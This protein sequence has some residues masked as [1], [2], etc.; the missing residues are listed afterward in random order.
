MFRIKDQFAKLQNPYTFGVPV[1]GKDNFFGRE[2]E[3]Q[4]IFDTLENVPR[5]QKQDLVVMGPR[6]IGKSSLL[7]RLVD[8]LTPRKDFVSVYIDVQ[9]IKPRTTR[10][11]FFEVMQ[12]IEDGYSKKGIWSRHLPSFVTLKPDNIPVDLEFY[13][14]K[15]DMIRLNEVIVSQNLPRLV[16]MFDEVELLIE[17]GGADI[18][19]WFRGLIQSMLYII[20][21]VSGA[22]QLYSL[23]QDYGSPFYNIFK[24]IELHPLTPRAARK[25]IEEPANQIGMQIPSTEVDKIL[26][27]AGNSPY[28][29][30]GMAHYLVETLNRQKRY[31]V[32][33]EDVAEVIKQSVEYLSPQFA[34][35]WGGASQVQRIILYALAK[36]GHPRTA[37]ALI[38]GLPQLKS[39]IQSRQQQQETFDNL[40]QQQILK[41]DNNLYWFVVLL[42][43]DWIL[44]K[45]DDEN[46]INLATES[47]VIHIRRGYNIRAIRQLLTLAFSDEELRGIVFDYPEFRPVYEQLSHDTGKSRVIQYLIEYAERKELLDQLLDSIKKQNPKQ[48]ATFENDLYQ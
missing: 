44:A 25:L 17:F 12:K 13:T 1:Q 33:P 36:K 26:R 42:F 38:A 7:Y 15:K 11:L 14:F 39:I 19:S 5:G 4:L 29:I 32:Y 47:E 8:L 3:L 20:F 40:V 35:V 24:T 21:V 22:E 45:V 6:R 23:T 46:I 37:E 34:Y 27:Y 18:L 48:Y 41:L 16:L 9:S 28:F 2:K 10:L 30:Q 31:E 43:V